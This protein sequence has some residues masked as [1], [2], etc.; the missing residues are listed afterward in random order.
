MSGSLFSGHDQSAG[1]LVEIDGKKYKEFYGMSSSNAMEK[2]YGGVAKYRSAEGKCV[3][4][5]YKGDVHNT[6]QSILGGI[7]STMTYIGAKRLKDLPKCTTFI[8][9]NRQVNDLFK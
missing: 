6:I 5:E 2:Y 3:R 4:V 7:R 8:R 9:V 1:D